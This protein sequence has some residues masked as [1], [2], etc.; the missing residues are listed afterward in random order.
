VEPPRWR[1]ALRRRFPRLFGLDLDRHAVGWVD[2][3]YHR[4]Y[5][6]R[7]RFEADLATMVDRGTRLLFVYSQQTTY[8]YKGQ[9][10]DW[11]RRKHWGGQV[12]VE[13]YSRADHTF[14]YRVDRDVMMSRVSSWL[15]ELASA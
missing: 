9:F 13:Y 14:R 3:I 11:L 4:E 2:E 8:A 10:W 15:F 7:E 5:P 6:T 12:A 1:R